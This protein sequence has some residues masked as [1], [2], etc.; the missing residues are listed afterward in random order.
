MTKEWV[1]AYTSAWNND[2]VIEKKLK[3]F[4]SVFKYVVSDRKDVAPIIVKIEKG[5]CVSYGTNEE[6]S[7]KEV[8]YVISADA[9]DWRKVFDEE[10]GAKEAMRLDGFEF[11]GPKLKALSNKGG[12]KRGVE[13]MAEMK[14]VKV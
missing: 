4:S 11:K 13:L 8:E 12:L 14:G 3:R 10:T 1:E 7:D 2:D 5:V 9:S 6:F